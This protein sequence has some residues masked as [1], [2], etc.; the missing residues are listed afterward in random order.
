MRSRGSIG[1]TSVRR[2]HLSGAMEGDKVAGKARK[3]LEKKARKK[4]VSTENY[5]VEP[6]NRKRLTV[7]KT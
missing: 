2:R 1:F 7:R 4:V 5:L 6:E 3:D